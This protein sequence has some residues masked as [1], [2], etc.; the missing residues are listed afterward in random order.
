MSLSTWNY[1]PNVP[2]DKLGSKDYKELKESGKEQYSPGAATANR[3]F[4]VNWD[5]R[6]DFLDAL[7]GY[8]YLDG[9]N[10][11]KRILPDEHPEIDNFFAEDA[12]VEGMGVLGASDLDSIS[13]T[14]AKIATNY[15]PRDYFVKADNQVT[16]EQDR[17]TSRTSTF[18]GEMLTLQNGV[19]FVSSQR[20]LSAP[21]GRL[22]ATQDVQM[23]WHEV[24]ALPNNPFVIPNLTAVTNCMG[25]VNSVPFD[26]NGF[27]YPPGT[28]L[29][30]GIDPKMVTGKLAGDTA[31]NPN[32][33]YHWEITMK[34]LYRNNGYV[35]VTQGGSSSSGGGAGSI[36]EYA[37]HNYFW[38]MSLG[39][40]DLVTIDG[41]INGQRIYLTADL[42]TLWT[43]G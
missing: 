11:I 38:E 32:G 10:S 31:T 17:Y 9:N 28:V 33:N 29:F 15:K 13:W 16:S 23:T 5:Y 4:M 22:T 42:N 40:F 19:K 24:P 14:N 34:F 35:T 27:N 25:K 18:A 2:N 3:V 7:L 43:I 8:S 1:N 20:V 37:G 39:R 41:R 36:S 6:P 30:Y 26:V 21:P 12:T